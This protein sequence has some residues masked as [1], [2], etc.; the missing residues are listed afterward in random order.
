MLFYNANFVQKS[1][2]KTYRV[3]M[4]IILI[5]IIFIIDGVESNSSLIGNSFYAAR[6]SLLGEE[7]DGGYPIFK[8]LSPK[9]IQT[10][11]DVE[12]TQGG[13][14]FYENTESVYNSISLATSISPKL[15]VDFTMGVTLGFITKS[16]S[17]SSNRVRG[18]T[19][20]LYSQ[21]S[22]EFIDIDCLTK[23]TLSAEMVNAFEKLPSIIKRPWLHSEWKSYELF[24]DK[25]NTHIVT[26]VKYGSR[27]YQHSFSDASNSYTSKQYGIKACVDFGFVLAPESIS[28]CEGVT[29]EDIASVSS[30]KTSSRLVLRGGTKATRSALYLSHTNELVMKFLM[31]ANFTHSPIQYKFMSIWELLQMKYAKTEHFAKALNLQAFYE[32]Y[33][34]FGCH[35]IESNTNIIEL[36]K[37][38]HSRLNTPEYPLYECIIAPHGCQSTSDCH[39][40]DAFWCEFRGESCVAYKTV[41][42]SIEEDRQVPYIFTGSG[43]AWEYCNIQGFYCYCTPNTNW[44]KIWSQE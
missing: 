37:F 30:L 39:Y 13:S 22:K 5:Y 3:N 6:T 10:I 18:L 33:L 29:K 11:P 12:I 4:L 15:G 38:N 26:E 23:E 20:S 36:Q 27:I 43:N 8:D 21:I 41:S 9:C 42:S 35:Y 25:Y 2:I 31:E 24:L 7:L 14:I 28:I 32:G 1:W 34:N 17:G 40:R 16:I 19:Y 44:E